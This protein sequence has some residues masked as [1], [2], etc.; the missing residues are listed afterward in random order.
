MDYFEIER[1]VAS[2]AGCDAVDSCSFGANPV[3]LAEFDFNLSSLLGTA[4]MAAAIMLA[5]IH[6]VPLTVPVSWWVLPWHRSWWAAVG[7]RASTAAPIVRASRRGVRAF[8]VHLDGGGPSMPHP[9]TP[10]DPF[11]RKAVRRG[12][13]R[14]KT[15]LRATV[16][17]NASA[18]AGR[19]GG[20]HGD[21]KPH[22]GAWLGGAVRALPALLAEPGDEMNTS[23]D[24]GFVPELAGFLQPL[25]GEIAARRDVLSPPGSTATVDVQS[26]GPHTSR[27]AR[28]P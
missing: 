6:F 11:S 7:G 14:M 25:A 27:R 18:P 8:M 23:G 28:R 12:P 3:V 24:G 19:P 21:R 2:R 13:V 20:T 26:T 5:L 4:A 15:A 1:V 22:G 9:R 17:G 10:V 16:R